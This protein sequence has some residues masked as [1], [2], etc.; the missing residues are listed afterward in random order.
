MRRQNSICVYVCGK[1]SRRNSPFCDLREL[2]ARQSKQ[3]SVTLRDDFVSFQP[4]RNYPDTE[5][6]VIQ[7]RHRLVDAL[8]Q[9]P[10]SLHG[11]VEGTTVQAHREG[12][13]RISGRPWNLSLSLSLLC[14]HPSD[15]ALL[16][17]LIF[18]FHRVTVVC[19]RSK[20]TTLVSVLPARTTAT[21]HR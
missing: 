11:T 2:N 6:L 17:F 3:Q 14:S 7:P 20:R 21:P 18:P 1:K 16:F 12:R 8:C 13:R 10:R 15:V 19:S 5:S 9:P 4:P